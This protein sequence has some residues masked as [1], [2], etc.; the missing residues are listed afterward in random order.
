MRSGEGF[1]LVYSVTSKGSFNEISALQKQ[2]CRVKDSDNVPMLLVANKCD[3]TN[4][5]VVSVEEGKAL[6]RKFKCRYVETS[7]RLRVN[8]QESFFYLVRQM[9]T[10][11][12]NIKTPRNKRSKKKC[13]IL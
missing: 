9:R 11:A 5:R 12:T 13:I 6:A 1:L 4:D 3:L 2:I 10:H 7:A 8:V